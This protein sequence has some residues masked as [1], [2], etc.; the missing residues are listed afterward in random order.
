MEANPEHLRMGSL[1]L[2][3]QIPNSHT[4][5]AY[6]PVYDNKGR[7]KDDE[8]L[9]ATNVSASKPGSFSLSNQSLRQTPD[10][11]R[12]PQVKWSAPPFL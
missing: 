7:S 9:I 4:S 2:M 1:P 12:A 5:L 10:A 11:T 3:T 8:T 6:E